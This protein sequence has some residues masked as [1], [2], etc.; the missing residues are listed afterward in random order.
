MKMVFIIGFIMLLVFT[1]W[2]DNYSPNGMKCHKL[3]GDFYNVTN[4]CVKYQKDIEIKL[5]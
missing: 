3:G 4:H 2:H 5:K 1:A